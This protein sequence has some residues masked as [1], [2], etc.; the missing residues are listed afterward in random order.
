MYIDQG[1]EIIGGATGD[2]CAVDGNNS[3]TLL[4]LHIETRGVHDAGHDDVTASIE[5]GNEYHIV[6]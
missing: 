4:H 2:A 3:I 5:I 1:Q 6:Q